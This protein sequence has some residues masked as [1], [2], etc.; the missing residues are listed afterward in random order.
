MVKAVYP[1]TIRVSGTTLSRHLNELKSLVNN[2][3]HLALF[4]TSCF[5]SHGGHGQSYEGLNKLDGS[6]IETYFSAGARDKAE[7][8]TAQLDQVIAF[9]NHH[10]AFTPVITLLVLSEKDWS[11]HTSFPVYGMPHY[12]G[13]NRLIVASHDNEFWK[14]MTPRIEEMPVQYREKFLRAYTNQQGEL[15]MESFFDLLVIHELG[16][17][18]HNQGGLRMQRKWMGELFCNIL[19][20]SYVAEREPGLLDALT[21][22]PEMVVATTERSTLKYTTLEELEAN[23]DDLGRNHPQ[24]YGWYQCRWHVAAA[25]IYDDSKLNAIKNLW[26]TLRDQKEI[27]SDPA[28][29]EL[30]SSKVHESVAEV[31]LKWS[32]SE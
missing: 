28:F 17:A 30:M 8:M 7:R 16:H 15:T 18:Y 2:F 19:L 26:H 32:A 24:N 12:A 3:A 14:S 1:P 23:Y 20:H 4:F 21:A 10:L 11:K 31:P 27:L 25:N 29:V 5:L 13:N 22:F 6:T 9:Y